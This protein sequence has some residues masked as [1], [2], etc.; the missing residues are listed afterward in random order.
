VIRTVGNVV[1]IADLG[2]PRVLDAARLV[3]DE[4]LG[5]GAGGESIPFGG[6][7][8]GRSRFNTP[9]VDAVAAASDPEHAHPTTKMR[10]EQHDRVAIVQCNASV[11]DGR[12]L[13][14]RVLPHLVYFISRKHG[15]TWKSRHW[16]V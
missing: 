8:H 11:V 7:H 9:T 16:T 1:R 15:I 3:L 6:R 13:E 10:T 14:A 12:D 5:I 4:G 2:D